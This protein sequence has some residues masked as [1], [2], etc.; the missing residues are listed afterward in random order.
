M[1][2]VMNMSYRLPRFFQ[3]QN[4]LLPQGPSYDFK[5]VDADFKILSKEYIYKAFINS[6]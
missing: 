1:L 4:S 5:R 6:N 3:K 2:C